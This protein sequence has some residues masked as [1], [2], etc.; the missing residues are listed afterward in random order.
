MTY[1]WIVSFIWAFSFG[2]IKGN[3]SGLDPTFVSF[4]RLAISLLVFLPFL[5]PK[6]MDRRLAF[7][8]FRIGIIQF[9]V[10]YLAYI[11]A[12]QYL[13]AYEVALFTIF[14]PL[15]V[16]VYHQVRSRRLSRLPIITALLAVVGTAVIAY[17]RPVEAGYLAGFLIVQ[18]SNLAFAVGQVEYRRVDAAG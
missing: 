15:Y 2:L 3:L 1:L 10:M 13:Q 4:A 6:K 9:G 8:L 7:A 5:H 16:S 17:T 18:L 12:F 11:Y 14:T